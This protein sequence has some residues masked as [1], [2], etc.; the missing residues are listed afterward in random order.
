VEETFRVDGSIQENEIWTS[1]IAVVV[2]GNEILRV[3]DA[4]PEVGHAFELVT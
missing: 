2:N 4:K 1:S 3:D